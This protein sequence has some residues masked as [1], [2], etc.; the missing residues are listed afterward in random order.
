M[1]GVLESVK[2]QLLGF[3]FEAVN[4]KLLDSLVNCLEFYLTHFYEILE[5]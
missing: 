3:D 4:A 2:N 5:K 1:Y